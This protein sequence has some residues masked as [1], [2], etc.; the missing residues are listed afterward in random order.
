MK[1]RRLGK[2]GFEVSEVSLGTWQVGGT[3]GSGFDNTNA[4]TI[5]EAA[6]DRGVN[7]IDTADVY[8]DRLSE[9]VGGADALITDTTY[10]DEEYP[11]FVGYGHSAVSQVAALAARAR[12][13]TLYLFHHDPDQ[14]DDDI[15]RKLASAR[16]ALVNNGGGSVNCVAPAEGDAIFV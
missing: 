12:V 1:Y 10:T 4:E 16:K 7:F 2:T 6:I 3:W 8:E 13:K 14:S 15:D 9:F 11:R 5:L